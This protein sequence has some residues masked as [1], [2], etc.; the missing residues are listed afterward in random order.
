M[1]DRKNSEITDPYAE[2]RDNKGRFKAGNPGK[3]RGA[4]SQLSRKAFTTVSESFDGIITVLIEKA[5]NGETDAAKLLLSMVLPKTPPPD[6]DDLDT[7]EDLIAHV[8]AGNLTPEDGQRL[9]AMF[10]T[11]SEAGELT[12]IRRKL[13]LLE[14]VLSE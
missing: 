8:S 12:E 13:E 9:A 4:R 10:K 11:I 6:V 1:N 3:P 5:L 2:T 14:S 7:P